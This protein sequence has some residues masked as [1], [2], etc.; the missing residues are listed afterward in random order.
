MLSSCIIVSHQFKSVAELEAHEK[1]C[2]VGYLYEGSKVATAKYSEIE[3][4]SKSLIKK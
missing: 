2:E 3:E 4:E 1:V